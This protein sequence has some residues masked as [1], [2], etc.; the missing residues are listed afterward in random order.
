MDLITKNIF[1]FLLLIDKSRPTYI[2]AAVSIKKL[3]L[4]VEL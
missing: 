1:V 2:S 3:R 4:R